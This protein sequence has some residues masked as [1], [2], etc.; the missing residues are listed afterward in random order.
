VTNFVLPIININKRLDTPG[1]MLLIPKDLFIPKWNGCLEHAPASEKAS[2][3]KHLIYCAETLEE[4][5]RSWP[6]KI[7]YR[8]RDLKLISDIEC[9]QYFSNRIP[10]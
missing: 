6:L 7:A 2:R 9:R 4:E 5:F 3:D 1:G 8:A 10:L